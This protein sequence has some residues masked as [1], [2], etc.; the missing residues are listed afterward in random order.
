VPDPKLLELMLPH[1]S[2][3]HEKDA[4]IEETS[5]SP[6]ESPGANSMQNCIRAFVLGSRARPLHV[7]LRQ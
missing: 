2:V 3:V 7:F 6:E 5:E 4:V 1:V